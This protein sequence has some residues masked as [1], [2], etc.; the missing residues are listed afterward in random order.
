MFDIH[1]NEC[2]QYIQTESNQFP[3][4]NSGQNN[5]TIHIRNKSIIRSNSYE[6]T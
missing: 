4:L 3:F 2:Q 1:F 5:L 6:V